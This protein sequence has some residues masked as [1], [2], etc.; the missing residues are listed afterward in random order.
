[1]AWKDRSPFQASAGAAPPRLAGREQIIEAN[2]QALDDLASGHLGHPMLITGVRGLGKTA[3]LGELSMRA[4][5]T[6]W[7]SI[8]IEASRAAYLD[9]KILDGLNETIDA[10]K[11]VAAALRRFQSQIKATA[12]F[13]VDAPGVSFSLQAEE[14][15]TARAGVDFTRVLAAVAELARSKHTG[16]AL[17]IDELHEAP[18]E[19]L[20]SLVTAAHGLSK[21][22]PSPPFHVIVAGLPSLPK[23]IVSRRTY[24]ERLFRVHQLRSLTV[25][26]VDEALNGPARAH[27]REFTPEAIEAIDAETR[28]YPFFVQEWGDRLWRDT[29]LAKFTVSEVD[30]VRSRVYEELDNSF[31]LLRTSSLTDAEQRFVRAMAPLG[32][33][34]SIGDIARVLGRPTRGV[35][36]VRQNL[37]D[38]GI[39]YAVAHGRLAFTIPGYGEHLQRMESSQSHGLRL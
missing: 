18:L 2:D 34:A 35:S 27:G 30:H 29:D 8:E 16:V 31:F 3:I 19:H 21:S 24:A 39:I 13:T 17:L 5:E 32:S 28:G 10:I 20:E 37:L 23:R 22:A 7:H 6:G 14:R 36:P 25:S 15:Q 11:P 38:K 26:Q 1:M 12:T 33:D 9:Q 4:K